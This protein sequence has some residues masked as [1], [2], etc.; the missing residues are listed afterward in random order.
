MLLILLIYV[1]LCGLFLKYL[2]IKQGE[3]RAC[4]QF[5][6]KGKCL[7]FFVLY[8]YVNVTITYEGRQ[9]FTYAQHLWPSSS[10]GSLTCHTCCDMAG[11]SIYNGHLRGPLTLT[12]LAERLAVELS[13]PVL[14]RIG[15]EHSNFRVQG[16]RSNRLRVR[17]GSC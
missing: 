15:F 13:L 11:S 10:G 2:I 16:K 17:R 4:M 6:C 7:L 12:L 8:L 1:S 3:I 14:S 9:I 5:H